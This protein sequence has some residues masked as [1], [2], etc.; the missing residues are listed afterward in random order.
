[1]LYP[2]QLLVDGRAETNIIQSL[3]QSCSRWH[4]ICQLVL[5]PEP[6]YIIF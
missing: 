5:Y 1:M 3:N 4:A 2:E 6:L